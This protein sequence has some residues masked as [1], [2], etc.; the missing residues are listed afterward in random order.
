MDGP[1]IASC[2][3][4]SHRCAETNAQ[5]LRQIDLIMEE[6]KDLARI[7]RDIRIPSTGNHAPTL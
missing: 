5:I 7:R 6:S 1:E 3:D 2:A 4:G